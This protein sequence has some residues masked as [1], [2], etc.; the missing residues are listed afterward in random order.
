MHKESEKVEW[1]VREVR[2]SEEAARREIVKAATREL[3]KTYG[4]RTTGSQCDRAP[5]EVLVAL[6]GSM[7]VGTSEY[8]R[9]DDHIYVQGV[10]VHPEYQGIGVCRALLCKAEEIAMK[11]NLQT[12]A[13]CAIEETGNVQ[14]FEKLGFKVI[15]RAVSTNYISPEGC[16]VAQVEMERNFA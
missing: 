10:A 2:E 15:S 3:R 16:P 4:P 6:I 9:K 7:L 13:L 5:N 11:D 14:I 12:L 8:I 1:F